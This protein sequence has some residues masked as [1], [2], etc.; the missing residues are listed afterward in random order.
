MTRLAETWHEQRKR[1]LRETSRFIEWGL[2]HPELT[3][4]IP[5]KPIGE[6]GFPKAVGEWF[7]GVALTTRTDPR[8]VFWRNFLISKPLALIGKVARRGQ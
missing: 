1:M 5:A 4:Q 6:G 2:K 8:I 7:W 3:I